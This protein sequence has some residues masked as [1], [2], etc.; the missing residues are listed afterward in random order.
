[1]TV[2]IDNAAIFV[3]F[4]ELLARTGLGRH[5][6]DGQQK[7]NNQLRDFITQTGP[8]L[9]SVNRLRSPCLLLSAATLQFKGQQQQMHQT[10]C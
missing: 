6:P 1:M 8:A 10:H 2:G 9:D 7:L 3:P 4:Q 5:C